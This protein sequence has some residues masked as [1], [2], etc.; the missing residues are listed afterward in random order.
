MGHVVGAAAARRAGGDVDELEPQRPVDGDRRVQR[1]RRLPGAEPD[2]ADLDVGVVGGQQRDRVAVGG[3]DVAMPVGA[4]EPH[5]DALDRRV[6]VAG[7][8]ARGRFL[9][10]HV[11]RLDRAAQFDLDAVEHRGADA[12]EPELGERVQPAGVE[13]DAVRAQVGGDVRDVLNQEVRQQ[14]SAVQVRAVPDQ[15]GPQRLVPEPRHQRAHQQRL[16]HRHLEVRRHLE[17][18]KFQQAQPAAGAVGA[19]ELVDAELGAVGVAG[20]VG[21]Q[22]AQRAVGD[23][24]LAARSVRRTPGRAGRSRRTRSPVRRAPRRGPRRRAAPA[25]WCRRTGRRTGTTARDG[26]ASRS[27]STPA[28]RGGA[29]SASRRA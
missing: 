14:V 29:A 9:A 16:H 8:A 7:G 12:R 10:E 6:D 3:D 13:V 20:D 21:Q 28:G 1:A 19:V 17:A 11:P 5:L 4:D 15:R 24:R 26:A 27:A 25:R 2:P 23:P 22:M 18:A